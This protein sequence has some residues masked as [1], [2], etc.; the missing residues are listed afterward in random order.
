MTAGQGSTAQ[1]W[2]YRTLRYV[3]GSEFEELAERQLNELGSDGWEV[4]GFARFQHKNE[5]GYR[6]ILKRPS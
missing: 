5:N 6:V 2:E 3:T 1:R 4:V